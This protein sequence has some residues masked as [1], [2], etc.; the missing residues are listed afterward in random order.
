[1]LAENG[2]GNAEVTLANRASRACVR[3]DAHIFKELP[4]DSRVMATVLQTN[5]SPVGIAGE[6]L[7]TPGG[8]EYTNL[9]VKDLSPGS[10]EIVVEA[11]KGTDVVARTPRIPFER[12]APEPWMTNTYGAADIVLPGFKPLAVAG[13]TVSLWGRTYA[14]EHSIM[15]V[16]VTNQGHAMLAR[17]INW[18]VRIGG[19]VYPLTTEAM[20]L[21]SSSETR[22]RY[23]GQGTLGPIAVTAEV[24]IEYDGFMKFDIAFDPGSSP[25]EIE[26]LWM[27]IPM[28]PAQSTSFFHPT[29]RSGTWVSN[30][31]SAMKLCFHN[32]ITLG[33]PDT[34]LQWM[35]E[36]D[37]YYYPR[38][39]G[40]T[41]KTLEEAG[42]RVFRN[43]VIGES[44]TVRNPFT[45]TFALH[46]G[47]VRPRPANWRGWTL[48]GRKYLDPK[49]HTSIKYVYDW[50]AR[51]PGDLTPRNGL[52]ETSNPELYK[53]DIRMSS[54]HFAGFRHFEETDPQ[55]RLPEWEKYESEWERI[56]R[57]INVGSAPGWSDQYVDPN[58]SWGQWHLYNCW[59]LFKM[60]GM[61]GLYYDNWLPRPSMNE[62][63]GS[64]Y[65][66]EDG[67]RQPI[68]PIFSQRE[69]QRRVYAIVKHFRPDDGM[70]IIH[71]A[72]TLIMPIISFC[73]SIYDGEIMSWVDLLPPNGDYFQTYRD[74]LFR[75]MFTCRQYG[76]VPSFH[77]ET[78]KSAN[79]AKCGAPILAMHNQR[80]LWAKLLLHDI[81]AQG[82]FTS[83]SE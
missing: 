37:Q 51:A 34:S 41:I 2:R 80:K 65:I 74:D 19:K 5:G 28:V 21:I 47:P 35:T 48:N 11:T 57:E 1:M 10:Y 79:K 20:T 39:Y 9:D 36:S 24:M 59:K 58:S 52:P 17:P 67:I 15:P 29:R 49:K 60:T 76:P 4:D 83:G 73:D 33:T 42:A 68:N 43:N 72:S 64:G 6:L 62:E 25:V 12:I 70:V 27:D 38:M 22:A 31:K 30:F 54:M 46:A 71:T 16:Q 78:G 69:I 63:A 32:I 3:V 66:D 61:R 53:G 75:A 50:W 7:Q 82:A 77:D 44:K 23:R 45:L 26:K 55:K 8:L 13:T 40:E 14:F 81:H 18:F 56:P